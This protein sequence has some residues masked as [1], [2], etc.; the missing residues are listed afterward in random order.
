[1]NG[2][3]FGRRR[4][5]KTTLSV[6]QALQL[7]TQTG[8]GILVYDVNN[9]VNQF[10]DSAVYSLEELQDKLEDKPDV[11]VYRALGGA[12]DPMEAT[13]MLGDDFDAFASV[14][15]KKTGFVLVVDESHWLQSAN[16][17]NDSLASF[18][19][20]S[21]SNSVHLLQSAHAPADMW[22][23]ARG[24]ASDWFLFH[25]TR[26]ADLDA[27][28]SQCGEEVREKSNHLEKHEYIHFNLDEQ[29]FEI[30][31]DSKSWFVEPIAA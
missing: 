10:P 6:Y 31:S 26:A 27:I 11:I 28:E 3:L 2:L 1:M 21:D 12:F 20:M 15:W 16:S 4:R 9:Q 18:V 8:C 13:K 24:L 17:C 22:S 29:S 5:G 30:V 7:Q 19:R 14:I 23:R 25:T